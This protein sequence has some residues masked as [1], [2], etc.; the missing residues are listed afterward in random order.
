M[1]RVFVA[2]VAVVVVVV[3]VGDLSTRTIVSWYTY[4]LIYTIAFPSH[5]LAVISFPWN[6]TQKCE[7]QSA[8]HYR[9]NIKTIKK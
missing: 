2:A 3:V 1:N 9:I 6:M 8:H 7:K 4:T 5:S